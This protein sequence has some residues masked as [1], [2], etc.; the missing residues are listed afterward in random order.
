MQN[1]EGRRSESLWPIVLSGGNEEKE[2][3]P[4]AGKNLN[5]G[6]PKY[7]RWAVTTRQWHLDP[8][9]YSLGEIIH[10]N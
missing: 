7:E 5:H 8:E 10:L 2:Q 4:P 1:Q 6:H 3:K 9:F